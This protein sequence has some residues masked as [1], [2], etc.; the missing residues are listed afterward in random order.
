MPLPSHLPVF[1]SPQ[2]ALK[3]KFFFCYQVHDATSVALSNWHATHLYYYKIHGGKIQQF[4]EKSGNYKH[5]Q[6]KYALPGRCLGTRGAKATCSHSP[7]DAVGGTGASLNIAATQQS[8]QPTPR[9]LQ[10]HT[11][12]RKHTQLEWQAQNHSSQ[13]QGAERQQ[14]LLK[15]IFKN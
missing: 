9:W 3:S 7:A 14:K 15:P 8:P 2:A 6:G 13:L 12:I 4:R 10:R 5:D 11:S 1:L